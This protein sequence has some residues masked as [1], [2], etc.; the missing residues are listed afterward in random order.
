MRLDIHAYSRLREVSRHDDFPCENEGHICAYTYDAFPQSFRGVPILRRDVGFGGE[1]ILVGPCYE[2]TDRTREQR[3]HAG[4]YVGYGRWRDAIAKT[5]NPARQSTGLFGELIHFA[6]NE[7][8]IGPD[9]ASDLLA[10]FHS[11]ARPRSTEKALW[12]DWTRALE[13]AA[14]GGLVVFT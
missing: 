14:D 5:Y 1:G 10:D 7:G 8:T 3:F 11:F 9:A 13:L 2:I 6:D 4:S 12:A